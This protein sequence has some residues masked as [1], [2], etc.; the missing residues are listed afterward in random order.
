MIAVWMLFAPENL[1][2]RNSSVYIAVSPTVLVITTAFCY[3]IL[4]VIMRITGRKSSGEQHCTLTILRQGQLRKCFAKVDT[5]NTLKEPFSGEPVIVVKREVF[6]EISANTDTCLRDGFRLIPFASVGGE[7]VLPA[8]RAD[9]ITIT[10]Q[11]N[12]YQV[13]AYVALCDSER[14][15]GEIQALVPSVL[16]Y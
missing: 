6:P 1:L 3:V 15:T 10:E 11:N 7:G 13:S 2:I 14:I 16:L 9:K 5:G 12:H 8:F 4:R